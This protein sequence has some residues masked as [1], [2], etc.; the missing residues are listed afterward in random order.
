MLHEV[1]VWPH[2]R[3]VR[4]SSSVARCSLQSSLHRLMHVLHAQPCRGRISLHVFWWRSAYVHILPRTPGSYLLVGVVAGTVPLR[5]CAFSDCC[6]KE[7]PQDGWYQ[8][9]TGL[10]HF[11]RGRML[12]LQ[13]TYAVHC[14]HT[15]QLEL[16]FAQL[17]R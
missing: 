1:H 6:T 17:Q 7:V 11:C 5:Q 15:P 3:L 8:Q 9:L 13:A 16:R 4:S 14:R 12:C 2:Q 10:V